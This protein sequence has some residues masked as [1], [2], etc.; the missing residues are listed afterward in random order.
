MENLLRTEHKFWWVGLVLLLFPFKANAF[1]AGDIIFSSPHTQ[2]I[3]MSNVN[4]HKVHQL[5]DPP[6]LISEM[7]IQEGDRYILVVGEGVVDAEFG[8][9]VYLFDRQNLQSGRKDLTLGRFGEICDAAIS[10]KGDVIFTSSINQHPDGL[11]L[12]RNHEVHQP[13]PKAEK[14]FSGPTCYVDWAHNAEEVV[15]SNREGIFLLNVF[16]KQVSQ[17][18]KDG[19]RPVFSPDGK[20]LAFLTMARAQDKQKWTYL[21]NI[22]DLQLPANMKSLEIKKGYSPIYLTWSARSNYIV[23]VA[24][25][26]FPAE[27][28]SF[29]ISIINGKTEGILQALRKPKKA[30]R[31]EWISKAYAIEPNKSLVTTWGKLKGTKNE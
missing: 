10:R 9:D 30:S 16:T 4:G 14:L 17:I 24:I 29:A 1:P 27:P 28:E 15:F 6:L 2:G 13:I 22:I 20:H 26:D 23:Y 3:W 25:A 31:L 19:Y 7:S 11:Y 12:I 21:I 5:F 18:A 8:V